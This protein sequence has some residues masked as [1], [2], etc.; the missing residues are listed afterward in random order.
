VILCGI[1]CRLSN[2]TQPRRPRRAWG[3]PVPGNT[4]AHKN[5]C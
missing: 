1:W 5:C 3:T 4:D 2:A